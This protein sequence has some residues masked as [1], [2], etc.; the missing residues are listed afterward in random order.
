MALYGRPT[1]AI[2]YVETSP[3]S[4]PTFLFLLSSLS[5]PPFITSYFMT[6]IRLTRELLSNISI[7]PKILRWSPISMQSNYFFSAL[8]FSF[9]FLSLILCRYFHGVHGNRAYIHANGWYRGIWA[10]FFQVLYTPLYVFLLLSFISPFMFVHLFIDIFC[11]ILFWIR[12]WQRLCDMDSI[13][14]RLWRS[15]LFHGC[16]YNIYSVCPSTLWFF[17]FYFIL[18]TLLC[19]LIVL[20]IL[21]NCAGATV[22]RYATTI[23]TPIT[24]ILKLLVVAH[25]LTTN[26]TDISPS[27]LPLFF[28]KR[29]IFLFTCAAPED[30]NHQR[31][32]LR[33]ALL[34]SQHLQLPVVLWRIS[35]LL[36]PFSVSLYI[37]SA[38]LT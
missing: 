28:Y 38:S 3:F 19:F 24:L 36:T 23:G 15:I 2:M 30:T 6:G 18:L 5:L 10:R 13:R 25:L 37:F 20:F 29:F 1:N 26:G 17:L 22:Q 27:F 33:M 14:W 4:T 9:L 32:M 7:S 11:F 34:A 21:T 12:H 35:P 8:F 16:C 31:E